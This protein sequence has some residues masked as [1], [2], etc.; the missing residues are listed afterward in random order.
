M[1]DLK[2]KANPSQHKKPTQ[3]RLTQ[4]NNINNLV[5]KVS[6]QMQSIF[7]VPMLLQ[8]WEK[9]EMFKNQHPSLSKK[10][11]PY[12]TTPTKMVLCMTI[13]ENMHVDLQFSHEV[14]FKWASTIIHGQV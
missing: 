3:P 4:Q 7:F 5:W 1:L 6:I 8:R 10:A 2:K 12:C 14:Y 9:N 11:K 13:E